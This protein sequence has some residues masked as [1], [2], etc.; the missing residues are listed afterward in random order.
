MNSIFK[1]GSII[2]LIKRIVFINNKCMYLK[3]KL[4]LTTL[5]VDL[6]SSQYLLVACQTVI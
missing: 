1:F 2:R 6:W 5:I 4:K 3:A